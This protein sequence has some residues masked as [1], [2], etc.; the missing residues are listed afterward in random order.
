MKSLAIGIIFTFSISAAAETLYYSK[1]LHVWPALSLANQ[2]SIQPKG[3]ITFTETNFR[4]IDRKVQHKHTAMVPTAK[5][6]QITEQVSINNPNINWR[7]RTTFVAGSHVSGYAQAF[8]G[9]TMLIEDE[10][11]LDAE[12]E[13]RNF[14]Y[15]SNHYN[16]HYSGEKYRVNTTL[17][18]YPT[19][20][21]SF[22]LGVGGLFDKDDFN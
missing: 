17:S 15:K 5:K 20:N 6:R 21:F 3:M 13:Y 11:F 12:V 16:K 2:I 8:G 22:H 19:D 9:S 7:L 4:A 1:V 10:L 14:D 18:W